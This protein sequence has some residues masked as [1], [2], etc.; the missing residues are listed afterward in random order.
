[1]TSIAVYFDDPDFDQYPF[2]DPRY[3]ES[4][5][6]LAI[7]V[8]M[9][10]G[11][12]YIVRSKETY[13]SANRFSGGY[14]FIDGEF[15]KVNDEIDLDLV[16]AKGSDIEFD[17]HAHI[18][19]DPRLNAVCSDKLEMY[20]VFPH[21]FPKTIPAHNVEELKHA[22]AEVPGDR[23]VIKP[24]EGFGGDGVFIGKKE[25]AVSEQHIFPIIVQEFIDTSGGI[26]DVTDG[27]HDY[28][29][30][31]MDG[32]IFRTTVRVP[33]KGK[34]L[35][36]VAQGGTLKLVWPE[37]RPI[38]AEQLVWEVDRHFRPYKHRLYSIDCARDRSGRWRLIE[39]NDQ[40]G[41]LFV[42]ELGDRADEYFGSFARY[43][44]DVAHDRSEG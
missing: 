4:Y 35:S 42:D 39:L 9:L 37:D 27:L 24:L 12:F 5:H 16:Y 23:I 43:L 32:D 38:G 3:R 17:W 19:S 41:L 20:K 29:I 22:I 21:L 18:V 14:V 33:A 40:P 36:N 44:I 25:D 6:R 13:I 28:R 31:M 30:I 7:A 34:M 11:E 26:E 15:S 2:N 8:Q 1:M 10:G